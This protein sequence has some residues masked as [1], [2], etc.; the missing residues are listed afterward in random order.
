MRLLT[1]VRLLLCGTAWLAGVA[2]AR[3][4]TIPVTFDPLVPFATKRVIALALGAP[5][6]DVRRADTA[7]ASGTTHAAAL[8][9]LGGALT[10]EGTVGGDV[11]AVASA[12]TLR[13]GA[14]LDG[15]LTVLGG[16]LS[17]LS[18]ARVAGRTEF[19]EGEPLAIQLDP[20]GAVRVAYVPPPVGF[21]IELKGIY[22]L[23]VREYN[24]VDGLSFGV[25]AGLKQRPTWPRTELTAGPVFRSARDDVGWNVAALRE[26]PRQ[27]LLVGGRAYN[28][29]DTNER[30]HQFDL[31]NSLASFF[32]AEDN[33]AYFGRRGYALWAER[34]YRL[35]VALRVHWQDD[36]FETLASEHPFAAFADSADWP[37]NPP[38]DEGHGR[39]LGGGLTW[40]RRNLPDF[41]TRGAYV[42]LRYDRWGFGGDYAFNLGQADVRAYWPTSGTSFVSARVMAG[43]RLGGSDSLA[44]QFWYRLGGAGTIPGYEALSPELAGDRMAFANLRYHQGLP[45][46]NRFFRTTW[47]VAMADIGDAWFPDDAADWNAAYGAGLAG[48]G[49]SRY[50][51]L[52]GAYGVEQKRWKLY[53]MIR[54]W[55]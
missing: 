32:L 33:R 49:Q 21:P 7:I 39:A 54:P 38:V 53:A 40:D 24:G 55:F 46:T 12:V 41:P 18:G 20:G 31:S 16:S 30:W 44:P 45:W 6:A 14:R 36:R 51:G 17:G 42:G 10:I 19:L 13:P 4:Q 2:G 29:T 23:V 11:T 37:V 50:L 52:F 8:V 5:G 25:V 47:L 15:D 34:S 9:Q 22:G 28:V 48:R 1:C 35:P 26:L 43:G 27:H 3:A